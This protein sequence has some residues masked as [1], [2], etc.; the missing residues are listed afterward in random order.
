[1]SKIKFGLSLCRFDLHVALQRPL[2]YQNLQKAFSYWNWPILSQLWRYMALLRFDGRYYPI[3]ISV[4]C[5]LNSPKYM[6]SK[7]L[8]LV[9]F[10]FYHHL[11]K[12]TPQLLGGK[13]YII[14][15]W[16][17]LYFTG[18]CKI[19]IITSVNKPINRRIISAT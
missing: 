11:A 4:P 2:C 7:S 5:A 14:N 17:L 3:Q 19:K 10:T 16:I 1:M 13:G 15:F 6:P 8:C 9:M 18:L 12:K